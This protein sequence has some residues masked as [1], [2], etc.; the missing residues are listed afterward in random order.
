VAALDVDEQ[1]VSGE[2]VRHIP[3]GGDPLYAPP[4]PADNRWQRGSVIAAW[5]FADEEGTAWAE[6]YR[7]LAGTGLPPGRAMPRDLWRWTIDLPRVALLD[8]QDR[9]DRVGLPAP[10][11][12]ASQWPAFQA[13]G[14]ALYADGV[15]GILVVSAARPGSTNLVVFRPTREVAGCTPSPPPDEHAEP[16]PVPTGMAT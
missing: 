8:T 4:H 5:Y 9:L 11:P 6:W 15:D 10:L 12:S 14:E 1:A 13:V 16:P 2:V 7:A 3:G